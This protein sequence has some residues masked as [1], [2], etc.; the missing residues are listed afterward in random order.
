MTLQV[1]KLG[2]EFCYD[3]KKVLLKRVI[4]PKHIARYGK[5][6]TKV[7]KDTIICI[8]GYPG[9]GKSVLAR[10]IA[11]KSDRH[12]DDDRNCIYDRD[13]FINKMET[14]KPSTFILDEA[15]NLLYKRDWNTTGQKEL[16][17]ILNICRSKRHFNIFVQPAFT[18]LD[19]D[20]RKFRLRMWIYVVTRGIG[21]VFIPTM[22]IAGEEDPWN[23][24]ENDQIIKKYVKRYGRIIGCLE[25]A[26][27]TRN[28][29]AYIRWDN[30]SKEEYDE[31][32]IVKDKKKYK[33]DE[34]I[35]FTKEE[36]D[37]KALE[38]VIENVL[39]LESMG[40]IKKGWKDIVCSNFSIGRSMLDN[41]AKKKKIELGLV[42]NVT[43]SIKVAEENKIS[44]ED[45]LF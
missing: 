9:E 19:K 22:S 38:K 17:K 2:K 23:L 20:I 35:V 44:E 7:K 28:F 41:I 32:E 25:G 14:F 5:E 30:I 36:A 12:Y 16:I 43:T 15:I 8:T 29:L 33:K 21:I 27:R 40:K 24:K 45:I 6:L 37:K 1:A 39:I 13:E 34:T 10:E 4:Y 42:S 18:D 31:Y 26:Y 11:K 3:G